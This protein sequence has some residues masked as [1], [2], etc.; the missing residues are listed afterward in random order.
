MN[1][2][3]GSWK[4]LAYELELGRRQMKRPR[5][6]RLPMEALL[7]FW[8]GYDGPAWKIDRTP[9]PL[10]SRRVGRRFKT[11]LRRHAV[12]R[13]KLE[14]KSFREIGRM[15]EISH[16]AAWKLWNQVFDDFFAARDAE[17]RGRKRVKEAF[18]LED[19][20][21]PRA[22][23]EMLAEA[24]NRFGVRAVDRLLPELWVTFGIQTVPDSTGSLNG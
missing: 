14:G 23:E 17:E 18:D 10:K 12:R 5:K 22:W 16:V 3:T 24:E 13:L 2:A 15:L 1:R 7:G 19:R 21:Y 9:Q 11:S 6:R 8:G 4:H 20:G